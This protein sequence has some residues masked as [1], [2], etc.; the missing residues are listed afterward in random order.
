[1]FQT[2]T[3]IVEPPIQL[4]HAVDH[5]S[6]R[7][8]VRTPR[9]LEE[10]PLPDSADTR[11]MIGRVDVSNA[12]SVNVDLTHYDGRELGVSRL[13]AVI[14][15]TGSPTLTDLDSANGT[16]LNGERLLPFEIHRLYH[17][18][19]ICLGMLVLYVELR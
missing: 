17:G 13:H 8:H 18:D 15:L 19:T 3:M 16:W 11:L 12:S 4:V 14:D 5:K 9:G 10:L 1:M 6:L 2:Q 7:L